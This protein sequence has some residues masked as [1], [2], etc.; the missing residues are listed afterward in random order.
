MTKELELGNSDFKS[1]IEGDKYF[2][3]KS[4]FIK[5]VINA[6]KQVLLFPRPRRFGKTLNLS[7]LR[8]F[9]DI[10]QPENQKLFTNLNI[11]NT[12]DKIK[13]QQGKFPVIYM[14][15]KDTKLND[16]N[17]TYNQ[18]K[19]I[20]AKVYRENDF[21]LKTNILTKIEKDEYNKLSD[22]ST[23]DSLLNN[24]LLQLS[25]Y[26]YRYYN[27]KVVILIDEYDAPIHAGYNTFYKEV[28][29]FMRS[30]LS[31]TFK[32]NPFLYKGIITGIL[33]VSRE[34]IF[35]GLNNISVFSIFENEISDKFGFTETETKQIIEDFKVK[36]PFTKIKKWYNGYQFGNTKNIY[37]P[38][39]I[40]N[41]A[42]SYKSGCKPFWVNTSSNDLIKDRIIEKDANHTREQILKLINGEIIEKE[43]YENFVFA[44]FDAK[45]E[46]FWTLLIYSGYLTIRKQVTRKKYELQIPNNELKTV[47]QDIIL[48][49]F[50]FNIKVKKTLLEE[51]TNYLINNQIKEF[52]IGFKTIMGDTFSYF[53]TNTEPEKIYQSYLLGLLALIGDDYVIKS[54]RE[55]GEGRYDIMLIPNN[56]KKYGIVIEIKQLPKKKKENKIYLKNRINKKIDEAIKQIEENNYC[57]ELIS[58]KITNIIKIP[59]IFVGKEPFITKI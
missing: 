16:W 45:K 41:L 31:A 35:S 2:V 25:E 9:F 53:D 4:L 7:M 48:D 3:D 28:I 32:D 24:S 26:L 23:N 59:I 17:K 18:I 40:L 21:L 33:R 5:D 54:N 36:I 44:D 19:Y 58:N 43:I 56:K 52:E 1:V 11:W 13:N 39:S 22:L 57:N 27:Q 30:L 6:Q 34:S 12:E 46:L 47:F 42:I 15:F 51:T 20:I 29:D 38:W 49:W 55:S 37:N 10:Q 8:Y 50:D 14:S